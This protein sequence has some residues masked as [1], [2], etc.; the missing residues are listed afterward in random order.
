MVDTSTIFFKQILYN[1]KSDMK[2]GKWVGY[3]TYNFTDTYYTYSHSKTFPQLSEPQRLKYE[4][5][6]DLYIQQLRQKTACGKISVMCTKQ[7][8]YKHKALNYLHIKSQEMIHCNNSGAFIPFGLIRRLKSIVT[9]PKIF[10]LL[11]KQMSLF[12]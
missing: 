7:N 5:S 11:I 9:Q 1:Q 3:S 2:I 10:L 12:L 8:L 4:H 6:T